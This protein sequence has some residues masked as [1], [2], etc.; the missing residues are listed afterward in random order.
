MFPAHILDYKATS[1]PP[2]CDTFNIWGQGLC[3]R[4]IDHCVSGWIFV[5]VFVRLLQS[6]SGGDDDLKLL[7]SCYWFSLE[8]ADVTASRW[9]PLVCGVILA[10]VTYPN[11]MFSLFIFQTKL[12]S[13]TKHLSAFLYYA[14]EWVILIRGVKHTL[15]L[16]LHSQT[17]THCQRLCEA[18]K[19][20]KWFSE[21]YEVLQQG[22]RENGMPCVGR[23]SVYYMKKN[24]SHPSLCTLCLSNKHMLTHKQHMVYFQVD[25][26][27]WCFL[28]S[29][30][31]MN[32]SKCQLIY[33][34]V[35]LK[36]SCRG[37]TQIHQQNQAQKYAEP[38]QVKCF[39]MAYFPLF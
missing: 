18:C 2:G 14:D 3:Q 13:S 20:D 32:T 4:E 28:L 23:F 17:F 30:L 38:T 35:V 7:C 12:V 22:R 9:C 25:F 24:D 21:W 36:S 26:F 29:P 19:T 10:V 6:G 27:A 8:W 5:R 34:M 39:L 15:F 31:C 16:F 33:S 11:K 1:F 37:W